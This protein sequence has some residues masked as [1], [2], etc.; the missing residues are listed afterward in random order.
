LWRRK[1]RRRVEITVKV[2]EVKEHFE[3]ERPNE[4]LFS[5]LEAADSANGR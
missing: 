2:R 5:G 1:K 3:G 4:S